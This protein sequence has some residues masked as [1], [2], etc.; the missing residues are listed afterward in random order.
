MKLNYILENKAEA[1]KFI[2]ILIVGALSALEKG[3][4][5]VDE[6]GGF[7]FKPYVA[8][9]LKKAGYSSEL[10]DLIMQGCE[11]EDVESLRPEL[12]AEQVT[13]LKENALSVLKSLPASGYDV[14][15]D[16]VIS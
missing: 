14:E 10:A 4:I 11:L 6:A 12:L 13:E 5:S 16:I 3:A 2:N 8:N 9:V 7:I 1:E 15:K